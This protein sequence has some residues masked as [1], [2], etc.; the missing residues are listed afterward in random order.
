MK[1]NDMALNDQDREWVKAIAANICN[2]AMTSFSSR[3]VKWAAVMV[4]VTSFIVAFVVK[5]F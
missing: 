1:V 3:L 2:E 4:S 5:L